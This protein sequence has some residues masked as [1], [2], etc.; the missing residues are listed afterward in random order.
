MTE[1]AYKDGKIYADYTIRYP[2]EF[3]E[4]IM[5]RVRERAGIA[6]KEHKFDLMLDVGCGDGSSTK[7]FS[8]Y[9]RSLNGSDISAAIIEEAKKVNPAENIEYCVAGGEAMPAEAST[10]D[11]IVS[12]FA[13]QYMDLEKFVAECNR[14]LKPTG[15]A[16][17][18]GYEY[19]DI[20]H[21]N[22]E[23]KAATITGIDLFKS[24]QTCL[25]NYLVSIGHPDQCAHDRYGKIFANIKNIEK[26]KYDDFTFVHSMNLKYLKQ[27][28]LS[29]PSFK[30][31]HDSLESGE[32]DP[33]VLFGEKLKKRWNVTEEKDEDVRI[34]LT[35]S[36]FLI[37][38]NK[39]K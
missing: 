2:Q 19:I 25:K 20:H 28:M 27:H 9:F 15:Y 24:Y 39:K 6:S 36:I 11:L 32:P 22:P 30:M 34:D 33:L 37:Y 35:F 29:I 17:V 7:M 3:A 16:A 13:L 1:H 26:E 4:T 12:G 31:F 8:S 21:H 23:G 5:Q 18:F 38:L 10:V 14:V